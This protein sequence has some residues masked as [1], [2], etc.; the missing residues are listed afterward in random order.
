MSQPT[1]YLLQ[2][3]LTDPDRRR[4][5]SLAATQGLTLQDAIVEA[6]DAWEEKLRAGGPGQRKRQAAKPSPK[7]SLDSAPK[8]Q[9][10]VWLARALKV[11]W[12]Q[13]AE[14]E[15][16]SDGT[17]RTWFLRGTDA[18]INE[19]M[20]ALDDGIPVPQVAGLFGLDLAVLAKVIEFAAA[21]QES[22]AL[23]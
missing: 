23:N 2:L 22:D 8:A 1:R 20:A 5:K 12:T 16:V 18:P 4:I 6:F 19:V 14:A 7:A 11:D 9:S 3:R 10:L 15:L 21:P 17:N 13:C